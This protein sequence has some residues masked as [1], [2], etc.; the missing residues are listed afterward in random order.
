MTKPIPF[1]YNGSQI[2]FI[3]EGKTTIVP[4]TF[5]NWDN[6]LKALRKGDWADVVVQA[7]LKTFITRAS[8]GRVKVLD[9]GNVYLDN[10]IVH[11]ALSE[12]MIAMLDV[13]I[14]IERF[15]LFLQNLMENPSPA[16]REELY[17]F[18]EATN[19]PV[20][21]DGH[22]LAYKIVSET[23]MDLY[24]GTISN[25][26]GAKPSMERSAVDDDRTV[27]CSRGLHACSEAYLPHYGS[28]SRGDRV[29]V[30]KINPRDVVSIP[31]DYNN[32]KMRVCAYEV[33][34]ELAEW[35]DR[36]KD[37]FTTQYSSLPAY[38]TSSDSLF[39]DDDDLIEEDEEDDDFIEEDEDEDDDWG[40]SDD[41]LDDDDSLSDE[42]EE[43]GLDKLL[44]SLTT[45]K[46]DASS[47]AVE[48]AMKYG[49]TVEQL[50]RIRTVRKMGADKWTKKA[51][52]DSTGFSP[53]QIG[54]ILSGEAW[55]HIK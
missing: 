11:N 53:R 45:E 49:I 41:D 30:V 55:S 42:D 51:I 44:T 18:L 35:R 25:A 40:N 32:A 9:D 7:N 2:T 29:V 20:T 6:V 26:I 1:H 3:Y 10:I 37:L 31:A 16:A 27:T 19:L 47:S 50:E 14:P 15:M 5:T 38:E 28:Q 8:N 36:L 33:V 46:V 39:G 12:R 22:F 13:G 52:S 43:A 54:R 34:D 23:Y 17:L 48:E 21:D 24:T 4:K